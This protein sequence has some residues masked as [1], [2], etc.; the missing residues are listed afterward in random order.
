MDKLIAD[1]RFA[2]RWFRRSP[3]LV[4]VAV[5]S[6]A[7]GVAFN[8]TVFAVVN[9][10]LLRPLP[11][12]NPGRLVDIYTSGSDGDPW[13][14]TSY[15]DY[16]DLRARNAVF[17]DIVGHSAMFAAVRA[18]DRARLTLGEI[19]TG[20]FFQVLGVNA[21]I[22]RTLLPS[23]DRNGAAPVAVIS[24]AYWQREFGGR[25][26]ILGAMVRI[27]NRPYAIVGIA[28]EGFSGMVPM[29]SA[30]LWVPTS[31][32]A[33]IEPAGINDV[34]PSPTGRILNERRGS[35][36]MFVKGRLKDGITTEQ[37][38]TNLGAI[39]RQLATEYPQ[40]NKD[41]R[42][43]VKRTSDVRL[44]PAADGPIKAAAAGLMI[45]VGL[46]LAIACAN[47]AS[48]LLARA[49]ARQKEI[50]IRLAIGASRRDLI[51]QL[52]VEGIL[53]AF[54]GGVAGVVLSIWALRGIG[55]VQPP[56]PVPISIDLRLDFRVMV[57]TFAVSALAGLIA[58]LTPALKT[59][60][61]SIVQDLRG[62]G[63]LGS[64]AGRRWNLRD[65]LV[66]AQMA[67]TVILLICAALLTR[68][69]V[70]SQRADVGFRTG[71]LAIVSMDP[72]LLQYDPVRSQQFYRGALD[73][74]RAIPGVQQVCLSSRLPFSINFNVEQIWVPGYHQ[75]GDKG[76]ATQNARVSPEYFETLG[77]P[78]LEGRTFNES[79]T[80]EAPSVI[81]INET[82]ARK[83]WPRESALGKRIHLR[84]FEGPAFQVVGVV[85]DHK[86][87][88]VGESPTP[89]IHFSTTQQF[90][91]Y[92]VVMVRGNQNADT[93]LREVRRTLLRLEPQLLFLDNQT[94]EGQI[95]ATLYP[96]R[97]GAALLSGA[98]AVALAL[99]GVGLYGVI[100][101]S[102][103][104]RTREIGIRVALGA[105][106]MSV[107]GLI[108]RQGLTMVSAGLVIGSGLG[109]AAAR[110]LAG[111]L[112]SV[113]S[114]DPL[115]WSVVVGIVLTIAAAANYV[116][117]RR[118]TRVD[119]T[120]ALRAE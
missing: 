49:S 53:L 98:G 29:L 3:G 4:V 43:S 19:V 46:V 69:L 10:L 68:S 38:A 92:Q 115:A 1:L 86:V 44:H 102:V 108:M 62:D 27:K 66:T 109:L 70:A 9:A 99:A 55:L 63:L 82:M 65:V 11:V 74:L 48:M 77:I 93:L 30:Q 91:S 75:P 56:I 52:L 6:L 45:S 5:A 18:G 80:P 72:G 31:S 15:P 105:K 111:A 96:I 116:P 84:G 60:S 87:Q 97:A 90:R 120:V 47:V 117:A 73:R 81:V 103:A 118:A 59:S 32:E 114:S 35:R 23:D 50:S 17:S 113:H 36:W 34:V 76:A 104:R 57:F 89:Y 22:G 8:T 20:N 106:R 119:P 100:A 26:D 25:A 61:T 14:T 39:M 21:V 101:Y 41:R 58:G 67:V 85:P 42:I 16:L 71:G 37:A 33:D 51:R 28:P 83:Y 79:D 64:V 112:Y 88:T 7:V 54:A 78:L 94:M 24:R 107:I 95:A 13:N 2:F 12:R 110:A 40:T